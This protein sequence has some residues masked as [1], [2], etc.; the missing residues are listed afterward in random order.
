MQP[1]WCEHG[2]TCGGNCKAADNAGRGPTAPS[3]KLVTCVHPVGI[4]SSVQVG[5]RDRRRRP[6]CIDRG[7]CY[8]HGYAILVARRLVGRREIKEV[9]T[10]LSRFCLVVDRNKGKRAKGGGPAV[11]VIFCIVFRATDGRCRRIRPIAASPTNLMTN[12]LGTGGLQ[13]YR[14]ACTWRL[15]PWRASS[16]AAF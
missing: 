9:I 7:V 13:L 12:L 16:F 4:V 2:G 11:P 14:M 6:S 5:R 10:S 1:H 15:A 8:A 3:P